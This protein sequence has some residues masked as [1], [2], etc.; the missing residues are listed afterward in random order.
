[1]E[2]CIF[3]CEEWGEMRQR[4]KNHQEKIIDNLEMRFLSIGAAGA[5]HT[6]FII[7]DS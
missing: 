5:L 2:Y 4:D 7:Y 3:L 1:V 6:Q